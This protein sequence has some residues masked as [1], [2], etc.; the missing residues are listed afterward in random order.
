MIAPTPQYCRAIM[1]P[2]G[3]L[4]IGGV[5]DP[6][7]AVVLREPRGVTPKRLFCWAARPL[8]GANAEGE[9]M[10]SAVWSSWRNSKAG[11]YALPV[12]AVAGCAIWLMLPGPSEAQNPPPPAAQNAFSLSP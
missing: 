5:A 11:L 9:A 12:I 7:A 2:I 3:P 1:Q 6:C 8:A 10:A 4:V